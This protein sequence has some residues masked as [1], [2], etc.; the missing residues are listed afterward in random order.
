MAQTRN[1]MGA[2]VFSFGIGN[3]VNTVLLDRLARDSSGDVIYIR[4]DQSVAEAVQAFFA[5]ISD[6]VLADP[7]LDF[8]PFAA[9]D[10][11]P[12][13]LPDLFAGRTVTLLGRYR[14]PGRATLSLAGSRGGQPWSVAFDVT[15]PE[16]ALDAGYVPRIWA[17]RQVGRLLADV[18]AGNMDPALIEEAVAIAT[19]FGVSTNFTY[20][21]ADAT[22]D[23]ALRYAAVPMAATG[24]A[25]VDTSS[26][27]RDY[28]GGSSVPMSTST[29]PSTP[30]VSVRYVADRSLPVQGGYLTDTKLAPPD[31]D[32]NTI[33][34]SFGSDRYFAFAAAEAP[35][36]AGALLSVGNNARFELLGRTFRITDP[37]APASSATA[38]PPE[39][40]AVADP[41][42]RPVPG[43]ASSV[44]ATT[45][46]AVPPANPAMPDPVADP[47]I[48]GLTD[49]SGGCAC[50]AAAARDGAAASL[51]ALALAGVLVVL[52]TRSR[53]RR[54]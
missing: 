27:L 51:S 42:W 4:P 14:Q 39:S 9:A 11:F 45:N 12:E 22:G 28:G 15:L 32:A 48:T 54:R 18:K 23:V 13:V 40:S 37:L 17:L 31:A 6:P 49:R 47:T 19:R 3:D 38:V 53:R 10:M 1:E 26:A 8:G 44:S 5:Q 36:G 50:A 30:T 33:D 29:S 24:A 2:R 43:A 35:F 52:S 46:T 21:A 20:F 25:A 41:A 7:A 16:Y 34:L